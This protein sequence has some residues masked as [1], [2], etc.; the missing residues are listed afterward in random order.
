MFKDRS[1]PLE[2]LD[3]DEVFERYRFRPLTI[4][5]IVG[6]LPD[7]SSATNRNQ[8]LPPLLQVLLCLRYFATGAMHLLVGDSLNISRSSAGRCIR[9]IARHIANLARRFIVFPTGVDAASTKRDFSSIAGFPNVLGCVD[10][11]QVKI[12]KPRQNEA[13]FVNRKGYHS[14]NVQVIYH[15][16]L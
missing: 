16:K 15:I 11:T 13:D 8:P 12:I 4:L 3:E 1:N 7:L 14:L 6:L 10:G 5:Y 9:A 2:D